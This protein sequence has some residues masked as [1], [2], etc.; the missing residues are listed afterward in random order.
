MIQ[1]FRNGIVAAEPNR[2]I[3]PRPRIIMTRKKS[4]IMIKSDKNFRLATLANIAAFVG[5][6]CECM[7]IDLP[8]GSTIGAMIVGGYTVFFSVVTVTIILFFP[9]KETIQKKWF[10]LKPL[11]LQFRRLSLPKCSSLSMFF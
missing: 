9:K 10:Q 7:I 4:L 1:N 11:T 8:L 5:I 2:N 3:P 6:F